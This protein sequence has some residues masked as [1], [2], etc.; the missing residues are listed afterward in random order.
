M[1]TAKSQSDQQMEQL[2]ELAKKINHCHRKCLNAQRTSLTFARDT[3]IALL[4]GKDLLKEAGTSWLPWVMDNC[5]FSISQVQPYM[6]IANLWSTLVGSKSNEELSNLTPVEALALLRTN[7]RSKHSPREPEL[8]EVETDHFDAF[9]IEQVMFAP[10]SPAWNYVIEETTR[11]VKQILKLAR[12]KDGCKS[13]DGQTIQKPLAAI[14]IR[15][16]LIKALE[17][18][19]LVQI[20]QP[21]SAGEGNAVRESSSRKRTSSQRQLTAA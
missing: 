10:D 12:S 8:L 3:G 13:K 15:K 2:R 19:I 17:D 18:A 14:A 7:P 4:K 20:Q 21:G 11:I 1:S 5:Q 16:Q 9:E 6:R